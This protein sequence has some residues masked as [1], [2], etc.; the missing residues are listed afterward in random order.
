MGSSF[1]FVF[2]EVCQ[3]VL[4]IMIPIL[5]LFNSR[6]YSSTLFYCTSSSNVLI[7]LFNSYVSSDNVLYLIFI[8]LCLFNLSVQNRTFFPNSISFTYAPSLPQ[9]FLFRK[10]LL[11][12]LYLLFTFPTFV[13]INHGDFMGCFLLSFYTIFCQKCLLP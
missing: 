8:V 4:F 2:L 10:S 7:T 3:M 6:F 5:N 12:Y 1:L 9:P 13:L 11:H